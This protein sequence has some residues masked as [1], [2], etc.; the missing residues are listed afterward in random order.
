MVTKSVTWLTS[1]DES[2]ST[3][4]RPIYDCCYTKY[5]STSLLA[6]IDNA[7]F[8]VDQMVY[9]EWLVLMKLSYSTAFMVII[10][11]LLSSYSIV[12]TRDAYRILKAWVHYYY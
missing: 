10:F 11:E 2:A 9:N 5:V 3:F 8:L 4:V 7:G 6:L 1:F 12:M